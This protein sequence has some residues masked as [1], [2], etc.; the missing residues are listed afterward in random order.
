VYETKMDV[1]QIITLITPESVA[2]ARLISSF[3]HCV[4]FTVGCDK[5]EEVITGRTKRTKRT[6]L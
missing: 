2:V 1:I 5:Q 6:K 4:G 3:S